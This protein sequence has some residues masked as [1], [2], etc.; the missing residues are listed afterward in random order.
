MQMEPIIPII[1]KGKNLSF[2]VYDKIF[3]M[4]AVN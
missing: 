3:H 2:E 1:L 4:K